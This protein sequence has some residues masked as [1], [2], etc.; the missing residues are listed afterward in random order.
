[1]NYES[2]TLP[3]HVF[4]SAR[5]ANTVN[6]NYPPVQNKKKIWFHISLTKCALFTT[7]DSLLRYN[8]SGDV[9]VIFIN[10]TTG[11]L[12]APETKAAP[13][14]RTNKFCEFVLL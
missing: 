12:S 10:R 5:R 1:M 11:F 9:D 3:F 13:I 4:Q 14:L 8:I 7:T 2:K 6:M